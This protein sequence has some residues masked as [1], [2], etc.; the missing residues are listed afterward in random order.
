MKHVLSSGSRTNLCKLHFDEIIKISTFLSV[1][2]AFQMT[3][4]DPSFSLSSYPFR[5][6]PIALSLRW[7][8]KSNY[9]QSF[10]AVSMLQPPADFSPTSVGCL[11]VF[12]ILKVK[13]RYK[14]FLKILQKL[15]TEKVSGLNGR[16]SSLF[17]T[18]CSIAIFLDSWKTVIVRSSI[19]LESNDL[20]NSFQFSLLLTK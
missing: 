13:F 1:A 20:L 7:N 4:S 10:S 8:R 9:L 17:Q 2:R 19:T 14:H 6:L 11:I 5:M 16:P 3:E 15:D 12:S 18:S